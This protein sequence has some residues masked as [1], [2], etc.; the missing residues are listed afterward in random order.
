MW[1][2]S[3]WIHTKPLWFKR[4]CPIFFRLLKQCKLIR[5]KNIL[6]RIIFWEVEERKK[7][8]V[9][10]SVWWGGLGES[11]AQEKRPANLHKVRQRQVQMHLKLIFHFFFFF[12]L[13]AV[14]K[15]NKWTSFHFHKF[16]DVKIPSVH[17]QGILNFSSRWKEMVPFSFLHFETAVAF[18]PIEVQKKKI[19]ELLLAIFP[20]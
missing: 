5:D 3:I 6:N 17:V 19:Y 8:F 16:A 20:V 4:S 7:V 18:S 10:V 13:A 2:W 11:I 15:R 14:I 1:V 12:K 9:C